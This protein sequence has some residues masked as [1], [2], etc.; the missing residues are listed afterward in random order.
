LD[1]GKLSEDL[2]LGKANGKKIT[3]KKFFEI[4]VAPCR[5]WRPAE[6]GCRQRKEACGTAGLFLLPWSRL[7]S[8]AGALYQGTSHRR[9]NRKISLGFSG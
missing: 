3:E 5:I 6:A 1:V 7:S 9:L 4:V 2:F 8:V